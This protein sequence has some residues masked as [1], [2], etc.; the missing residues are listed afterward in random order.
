MR[1]NMVT[2]EMVYYGVSNEWSNDLL[3]LGSWW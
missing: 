3:N 1:W 2:K